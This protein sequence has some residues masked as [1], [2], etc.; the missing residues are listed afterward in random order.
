MP[1]QIVSL[2]G[3]YDFFGKS[4]PGVTLILGISLLLPLDSIPFG[5]IFSNVLTFIV[6]VV[7]LV[8]LGTLFG[9]I[10]H[11]F[12]IIGENITKSLIRKVRNFADLISGGYYDSVQDW[13]SK[14]PSINKMR[15]S[16]TCLPFTV[17][18]FF[19][20][21]RYRSYVWVSNRVSDIKY[22]LQGHR[23]IFYEKITSPQTIQYKSKNNPESTGPLAKSIQEYCEDL[24]VDTEYEYREVYPLVTSKLSQAEYNRPSVFHSRYSF[25]R[26]MWV[27]LFVLAILY[28]VLFITNVAIPQSLQFTQ[29]T[30]LAEKSNSQ[31]GLL[32]WLLLFLSSLF[33]YASGRYKRYYIEYLFASMYHVKN[34]GHNN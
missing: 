4:F 21:W 11:T 32:C 2:F 17:H 29:S 20:N 6:F 24:E 34:S 19:E 23:D 1:S 28:Y 13:L 12:A 10:V 30:Y 33:A 16:N 15:K 27:I 14:E 26:S 25:C 22:I 5:D 9:E 31:I 18:L 3:S 8:L 7:S